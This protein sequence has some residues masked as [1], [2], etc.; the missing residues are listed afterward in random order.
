MRYFQEAHLQ[1]AVAN[2]F[3]F[4]RNIIV[5]NVSWGM[6]LHECDVLVLTPSGL[7]Y[8]IECKTT[9]AD[10]RADAKKPH[11]HSSHK[12]NKLY[13]AV[14]SSLRDFALTCIPERA[15][16][17]T[18]VQPSWPYVEKIREARLMSD[19]RWDT[20]DRLKL[21]HLGAMRIWTLLAAVSRSDDDALS[22]DP[23]RRL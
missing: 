3:S 10:L 18:L 21:A 23:P 7:A 2:Y 12:I 14:P 8:E 17:L 22:Y 16:L 4:R 19:R 5:P 15:G 13:F 11:Q 20:E 6:N 1:V 9:K